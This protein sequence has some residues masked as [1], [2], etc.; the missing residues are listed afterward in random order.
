LTRN[1]SGRRELLLIFRRGVWDLP[2]GKI[3]P[4]ETERDTAI[5]EVGEELGISD[6]HVG[7]SL[8]ATVHGYRHKDRFMVKTTHWFEMTTKAAEFHP[9]AEE[10][11]ESVAWF[12]WEEAV[13]RLG[14]ESLRLHTRRIGQILATL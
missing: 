5:R 9:E 2:K 6:V 12:S 3:D 11:I 4:G 14:Y 1:D 7:R 8:G 13:R 10:G